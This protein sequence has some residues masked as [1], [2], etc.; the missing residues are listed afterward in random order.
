MVPINNGKEKLSWTDYERR[1][2]AGEMEPIPP[3]P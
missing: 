2:A 1:V 3:H